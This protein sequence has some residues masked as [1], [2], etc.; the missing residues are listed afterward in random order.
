MIGLVATLWQAHAARVA[1]E[2]SEYRFGQVRKLAN[3]VLFEMHNA[4]E[5]L[6]G[7]TSA[8]EL[9]VRRALE[10]LDALASSG[11]DD[12]SL[13]LELA[14]A[15]SRI[16]DIQWN[17]YYGSL[18]DRNSAMGNQ[19]RALAI[20]QRIVAAGRASARARSDLSASYLLVGDLLAAKPD[21]T[22][23]L[24]NYRN[25]LELRKKL[26]EEQPRDRQARAG[27]AVA[28]QRVGDTL[29]NPGFSN[30]GDTAGAAENFRL[31]QSLFE[32]LAA[33][34]PGNVD[35]RHSVGIGYEKLGVVQSRCQGPE[36]SA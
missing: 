13:Q 22:G 16:G 15:Y 26:V 35:A 1:R 20:R 6:P 25:S 30:L 23:A 9:L 4:I 34:E 28:Y 12:L 11:G 33:E 27:L 21:L 5:K 17:R 10:Y 3:S 36:G 18:G 8:R 19:Q 2:A 24:E 7:S 14:S 31:M 32:E 29:G